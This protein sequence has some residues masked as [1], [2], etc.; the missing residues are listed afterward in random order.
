MGQGIFSKIY[1]SNFPTLVILIRAR[2]QIPISFA[3][4]EQNFERQILDEMTLG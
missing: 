4:R 3:L 1:F 2:G